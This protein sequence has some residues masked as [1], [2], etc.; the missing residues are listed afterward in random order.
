MQAP[1][2]REIERQETERWKEKRKH[3]RRIG[4][5]FTCTAQIMTDIF[6]LDLFFGAHPGHL[7][8]A[9]SPLTPLLSIVPPLGEGAR[10]TLELVFLT[11]G[12]LLVR[13]PSWFRVRAHAKSN[14]ATDAPP[15]LLAWLWLLLTF[16]ST[17]YYTHRDGLRCL[18]LGPLPSHQL[19]PISQTRAASIN[20][21][22]RLLIVNHMKTRW[23]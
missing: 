15:P 17:I 7:S 20:H 12:H 21:I 16:P 6:V 8:P 3:K 19:M 22:Y 18:E 10:L 13:G 2:S 14:L 5:F 4:N 1:R 11:H 23:R 9:S